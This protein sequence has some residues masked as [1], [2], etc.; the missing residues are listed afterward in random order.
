MII[1]LLAVLLM[2]PL[3]AF[4]QYDSLEVA[5]FLERTGVVTE[6]GS[7]QEY[8]IN[9]MYTTKQTGVT[10]ICLL[11]EY[12]DIPV[13][14]GI[15]NLNIYRNRVVSFGNNWV[16]SLA[17]RAP[18][19]Q[20]TL[21]AMD[22]VNLSAAH[23]GLPVGD[24]SELDRQ[25]NSRGEAVS[26]LFT[27]G[28]LSRENITARLLWLEHE[29]AVF[30]CW[31]VEVHVTSQDSIWNVFIDA[32][33][34]EYILKYNMVIHCTFKRLDNSYAAG[35]ASVAAAMPLV[36]DS[37]Y[38]IFAMPVESPFHGSRSGVTRPW[39]DAGAGNAAT[40]LQWHD[41]GTT[42][43]T[44][45]RGNNVYAYED[46]DANNVPG[47]SPDTADL[48]FDYP[49]GQYMTPEENLDA[50]TT[51]LFYWNNITHDVLYQYGFDEVSGNFQND[52]LGRGGVDGDYVLAECQD[53]TGLDN[54]NFSISADGGTGRMQMYLWSETSSIPPLNVNSPASITGAYESV[55]SAFSANNKLQDVGPVTGD[56]VLVMD[57]GDSTHL[58]CGVI[59]NAGELNGKIALIDRG[60]CNFTL[61][62][63]AVQDL[64]AIGAV[65]VNNTSSPIFAMG[66][67]D[68]TITIPAVM[69]TMD[70]GALLKAVLDTALVN[71]TLDTTPLY[72]PDGSFDNGIIV[73]E[74]GHGVSTRLTG[75]P[76]TGSCLQNEEQMGEGW[77]DFFGLMLTTDWSTASATD[78]RGIG[79]Y[80]VGQPN[81]GAGIRDY[82]YTTDINVNPLTYADVADNVNISQ[83]HGI[84]SIWATM[85][86]EMTWN[87]I[88]TEGIDP[89]IYHGTG[90]NNIA[91]HLVM[92][93]LKLQPC[94]PGFVDGRDA[95]LL[96]DE[97]LYNGQHKCAIWQAFA[98]RGLGV[99]ADQGSSDDR[100]DGVESYDVPSGMIVRGR[101]A[102]SSAVEGQKVT[103]QVQAICECT[104]LSGV[105]VQDVLSDQLTYVPGSGGIFNGTSVEFNVGSLFSEDT[106]TYEYEAILAGCAFSAD[107]S[108]VQDDAE[109]TSPFESI[110]LAGP[111]NFSWV[112]TTSESVSP[113]HSWYADD[114][115]N[116]GDIALTMIEPVTASGPLTITFWHRYETEA[117]YDGGVVEYSTDGGSS[118]E[119]ADAFFVENGYPATIN[120]A[121]NS[122]IAGRDAFT[123]ESDLQFDTTGFVRSR[124]ELTLA[125]GQ[126]FKLRFRSATDGAVG[127]TGL[128]GWYIDDIEVVQGSGISNKTRGLIAGNPVDSMFYGLETTQFTGD[129]IYVDKTANGNQ[130]GSS[131][132]NAIH[133]LPIALEMAGCH[134]ADSVLVAE[135]MYVPT[136]DDNRYASFNFGDSTYLFGGFPMG[137]GPLASRNPSIFTTQLTGD[138]GMPNDTTDNVYHVLNV[139]STSNGSIIDGVLITGGNANGAGDEASG[140]A[141]F[142][143]GGLS[144]NGVTIDQNYGLE[145][146]SQIK[147][148]NGFL[149]LTGCSLHLIESPSE[150]LL[151]LNLGTL[152]IEGSTLVIKQGE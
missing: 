23:L 113:T 135:G 143:R 58:A 82:P 83:P 81:D 68:N 109:G 106:V 6:K 98:D 30:L 72:T 88:A 137:G 104:D 5:K 105:V 117:N 26:V 15:L 147:N 57:Q 34:G 55:E 142:N 144:L 114:Y 8:I 39:L 17:A 150:G 12:R 43:Y 3:F 90:G 132:S 115:N 35:S 112:L 50:A 45:T 60:E 140:S 61:K 47:S 65:V 107:T 46:I 151:N 131:W 95:I 22:A 87:I 16:T 67:T 36:A 148:V 59:S 33:T 152:L 11:Q 134:T 111:G 120:S 74:Y 127:G 1:R 13:H 94:S 52:N 141:I 124:I 62:V 69:M 110:K 146:G 116:M 42:D 24:V 123:G 84:G 85:L 102:D 25:F 130:G 128:D 49:Y 118:W 96:A 44:I 63:S 66:G 29:E 75:G 37:S 79:T 18:S 71:V 70:D 133:F 10:H 56:L 20:E 99:N 91:L 54:A 53:G 2:T 119:D 73:H 4:A 108:L 126:S 101:S 41:D 7:A 121:T 76:S 14:N 145:Q 77:S 89:D 97:I 93:G 129:K 27:P 48:R 64:G 32:V 40:T 19:G 103:F 38:T 149:K 78:L 31:Q 138:I 51:N 122:S 9:D 28:S 21:G 125:S 92:N 86:W 139:D 80:A 100:F 136:L